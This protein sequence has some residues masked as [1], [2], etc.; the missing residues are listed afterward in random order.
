MTAAM[1]S[2]WPLSSSAR[3]TER[4]VFSLGPASDH[5]A[6]SS[7]FGTARMGP[8]AFG[9]LKRNRLAQSSLTKASPEIRPSCASRTIRLKRLAGGFS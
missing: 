3:P 4:I 1:A 8:R 9:K 2:L 5:S 6:M 7:P